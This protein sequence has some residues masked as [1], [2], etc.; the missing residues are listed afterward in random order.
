[1]FGMLYRP[2]KGELKS[3]KDLVKTPNAGTTRLEI[4]DKHH[5]F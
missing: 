3:L 2:K 4:V 5:L 1:M